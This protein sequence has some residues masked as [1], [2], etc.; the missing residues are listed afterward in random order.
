[1]GREVMI[2][3]QIQEVE[4][5]VGISKKNIRFYESEGLIHPGRNRENG[6]RDYR[7]AEVEMLK[8][9]RLLRQL[10]LP[11]EEI[12]RLQSGALNL[13]DAMARQRIALGREIQNLEHCRDLCSSLE[14][15]QP[16]LENL[17]PDRFL[18]KMQ[19]LEQKGAHFMDPKQQDIRKKMVGPI[20]AAVVM[21][22]LMALVEALLIWAQ[23]T[24]PLP[25]ALFLVMLL[26]PA[27]VVVGVVLALVSRL[28]EVRSGEAEQAEKY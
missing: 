15:E 19:E 28:K 9:I 17:D 20:A 13:E 7:P 25:W 22:V 23:R 27:A 5:Q 12:R 1:M 8:K 4:A 21:G 6:Y 3:M 16:T 2:P 10:G 24:D 18:Q 14:A 11:L 26:A